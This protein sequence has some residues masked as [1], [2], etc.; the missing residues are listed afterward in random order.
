MQTRW[1]YGGVVLYLAQQET[2]ADVHTLID[3]KGRL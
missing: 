3:I 2:T 1:S